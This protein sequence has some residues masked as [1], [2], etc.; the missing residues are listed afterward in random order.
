MGKFYLEEPSIDRKEEALEY[1]NEFVKF[2]SEINGV[3]SMDRCLVGG[4]M[5]NL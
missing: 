3:G 5:K 1:L 2:D 4:H